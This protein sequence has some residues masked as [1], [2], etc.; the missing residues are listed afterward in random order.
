MLKNLKKILVIVQS[1]PDVD[2]T[3]F[4]LNADWK[5]FY[6]YVVEEYPRRISDPLG[7][8]VY[9]GCFVDTEHGG[10]VITSRL[11]SRI[12]LFVNN[13]LITFFIK[14]QNT[15]KSSMFGPELV[16]LSI[17]RYI[18]VEV[19]IKLKMFGVPLTGPEILFCDNNGIVNNTSI[20]EYTLSGK[21]SVIDYHYVREAAADGI[22]SVR[23]EDTTMNPADPLTNFFPYSRNKNFLYLF[24]TTI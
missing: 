22:L 14:R 13:V 2:E 5:E 16:A 21:H 19:R 1:V 17:T 11:Q 18:I 24:F 15:V 20:P 7:R 8:P 3:I 10:N 4:N 12:L 6:R 9:V 23:K